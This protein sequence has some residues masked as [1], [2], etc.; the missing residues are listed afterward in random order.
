[1]RMILVFLLVSTTAFAAPT[2]EH[3]IVF[4]KMAKSITGDIE[5]SPEQITADGEK[6]RFL[7]IGSYENEASSSQ[8]FRVRLYRSVVPKLLI[9]MET[10]CAISGTKWW[11]LTFRLPRYPLLH[12]KLQ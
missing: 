11:Q 7:Y 2:V 12:L 8:F 3:W 5:L 4:S 10:G 9:C 1:M 6:L